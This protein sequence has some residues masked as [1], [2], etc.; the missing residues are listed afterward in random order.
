MRGGLS[1]LSGLKFVKLLIQLVREILHLSG[2]SQGSDRFFFVFS[3]LFFF[4]FLVE[5]Y[6]SVSHGDD[7]AATLNWSSDLLYSR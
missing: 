4:V 6:R 3:L 2:K 7:V 5:W 1:P